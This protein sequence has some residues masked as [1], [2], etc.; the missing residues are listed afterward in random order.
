MSDTT[1]EAPFEHYSRKQRLVAWVS[2]NFFDGI[3]Y[4]VRHGLLRGMKRKGG[5]GWI[6]D[7]LIKEESTAESKFWESAPLRDAVVY[8]IGAFHGMLTLWF[9][10]QAK[11]VVS[12]E[13]VAQNRARLLENLALNGIQNVT[14]RDVALGSGEGA[15]VMRVNPLMP[16]GSKVV[17][18]ENG[19]QDAG[20]GLANGRVRV[21]TLDRDIEDRGLPAPTFVKIDVEGFELDVLRGAAQTLARAR[22][23]LFI[24]IHGETVGGKQ[25]NA[26]AVVQFLHEAGYGP[27]QHVESGIDVSPGK[28]DVA[29]QGHLYCEGNASHSGSGR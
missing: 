24:E 12:Y 3:T 11:Q 9:A 7:S 10:P 29:A 16:G 22:P 8:D 27:I 1:Q 19:T 6:P 14:V 28:S 18:E 21:T 4:T 17:V 26:A 20:L 13:P 5:L 15:A 25:R 2:R 23:S